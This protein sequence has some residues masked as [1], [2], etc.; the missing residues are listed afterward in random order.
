MRKKK[1]EASNPLAVRGGE[2]VFG[3]IVMAIM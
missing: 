3:Y 2:A 1:I